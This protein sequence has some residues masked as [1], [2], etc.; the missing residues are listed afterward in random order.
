MSLS[1]SV[2]LR[3]IWEHPEFPSESFS[4]FSSPIPRE[5]KFSHSNPMGIQSPNSK[6]IQSPNSNPMGIQSTKFQSRGNSISQFQSCGNSIS[7]SHGNQISQITIPKELHFPIPIPKEFHLPVPIPGES[8]PPIPI[9]RESNLPI[10]VPIPIPKESNL[11]TPILKEFNFL[12][13]NPKRIPSPKFQSQR[14][15]IPQISNSNPLGIPSPIPSPPFQSEFL[16]PCDPWKS[17]NPAFWE[18]SIVVLLLQI[19]IPG[20]TNPWR[21]FSIN[22][23]GKFGNSFAIN[24]NV[25]RVGKSLDLGLLRVGRADF[26]ASTSESGII[27]HPKPFLPFPGAGHFPG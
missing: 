27:P 4:R 9:L 3:G 6:G 21:N 17:P 15:Q 23:G 1:T 25:Q 11:P 24:P 2:L 19:P 16:D 8:N 26:L 13:S 14:N 22:G 18:S 12:N 5:I 10:P 7:Q 20:V